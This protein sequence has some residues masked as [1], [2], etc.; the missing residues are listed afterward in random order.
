MKAIIK[1]LLEE[2][3]RKNL[4]QLKLAYAKAHKANPPSSADI[5]AH[6]SP[7]EKKFLGKILQLKPVRSISGI[8][9]I[10][11]MTPPYECP[12]KC[13]YCPQG[14]GSPKSYTGYEPASRRAKSV[15]YDPYKQVRLRLAQLGQTG[16]ETQKAELI[17]MGGTFP[18]Q[19]AKIQRAFV[20]NCIDALNS[21]RSKTIEEAVKRNEHAKTRCV[22][23]TFESRPDYCMEKE[24]DSML[25][26]GCTR[27]ELG[28]QS[29]YPQVLE[30][31]QR[32]H[33]TEETIKSTG[34]L[35]NSGLKVNYHIMP[36][37]PL[38]TAKMDV[39]MFRTLFS[40]G[41]FQPDMLKIYPCLVIKGTEL[42]ELW[43]KKEFTPLT[44][45]EAV[46]RIAEGI[47]YVPKYVR[48]MRMMRDIPADQIEAG[49]KK[50]HITDL[51]NRR[52]EEQGAKCRC[53]RCREA[54]HA[55]LKSRKTAK[56]PELT[57]TIYEASGGKE[58]FLAYE[59]LEQDL[60]LGYLRLRFPQGS[61]RKE[62]DAS[63]ALIRE[64]RVFGSPVPIGLKSADS[65]QHRGIGKSLLERAGE[66]SKENGKE[67]ILVTSA[68]GTRD[69]Y[70]K[71][72]YR[73][74]APYMGKKI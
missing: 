58:I 70:R 68:I 6:C 59:D 66:L 33:G 64:L 16:H 8:A 31:V 71:F 35:K 50:S 49:V 46:E 14:E 32:G 1:K 37:L 11:A 40:D 34:L 7:K 39:E 45:E 65:Y 43:K 72:G 10:A 41:R 29:L 57:E 53:I 47:K 30:Y 24:I 51:V 44:A 38:T 60:L 54:G 23:I 4:E 69:Y 3:T 13:I 63:T 15:G 42:H 48:I 67:K 73:L 36:G 17:I 18:A 22:G 21:K 74:S 56:K 61:H 62:I 12:G 5:Y 25:A 55:F 27:V 19:P 9:V 26:M 28:V 2:P 20:K 52:L